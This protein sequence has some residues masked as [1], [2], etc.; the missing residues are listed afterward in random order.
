M[1]T[2]HILIIFRSLMALFGSAHIG[3]ICMW[4]FDD[5]NVDHD[6]IL[7]IVH[8]VNAE[9]SMLSCKNGLKYAIQ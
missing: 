9:R 1:F 6:I 7:I 3:A 4:V 2:E 8:H 5:E